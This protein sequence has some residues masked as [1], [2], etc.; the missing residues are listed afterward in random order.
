MNTDPTI[1][2][3]EVRRA[4]Y[5]HG[6]RRIAD[7]IEREVLPIPS[8]STSFSWY[9]HGDYPHEQ[10]TTIA[11]ALGGEWRAEQYGA[12]DYLHARAHL[13]PGEYGGAIVAN[14]SVEHKRPKVPNTPAVAYVAELNHAAT[15]AQRAAEALDDAA[16]TREQL[17]AE[18]APDALVCRGHRVDEWRSCADCNPQGVER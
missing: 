12:G 4:R 2:P 18:L 15:E 1:D 16:I 13:V 10:A 8:V 7:L 6:L 3:D 5:V 17:D 9:P 14:I 11:A